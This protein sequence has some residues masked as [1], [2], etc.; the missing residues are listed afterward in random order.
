[1]KDQIATR[2][3][4]AIAQNGSGEHSYGPGATLSVLTEFAKEGNLQA[5]SRAII[6]HSAAYPQDCATLLKRLPG[7]VFNMYLY[8]Y[9]EH[10]HT[11]I[12]R[13]R[14]RTPN[15]ETVIQ[16]NALHPVRFEMAVLN[17]SNEIRRAEVN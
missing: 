12:E 15:W 9:C 1:M 14:S 11:A 13:W 6:E 8:S 5:M 7:K 4:H 17:M 10:S 3:A 16:D 2:I